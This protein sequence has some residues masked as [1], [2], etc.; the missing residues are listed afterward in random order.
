MGEL[1]ISCTKGEQRN[2]FFGLMIRISGYP[3]CQ[4]IYKGNN[5]FLVLKSKKY[6]LQ[7]VFHSEMLP[8]LISTLVGSRRGVQSNLLWLTFFT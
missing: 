1:G 3:V 5:L 6:I 2:D 8:P 7:N 4:T